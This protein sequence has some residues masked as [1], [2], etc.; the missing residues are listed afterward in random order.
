MES[1]LARQREDRPERRGGARRDRPRRE[2]RY[3]AG[4]IALLFFACTSSTPAGP[5]DLSSEGGDPDGDDSGDDSGSAAV[6]EH[7]GE[8]G[9]NATWGAGE[10]LVTCDVLADGGTLLV[11]A[12]A[13]VSFADGTGLVVGEERAG[14]LTVAGSAEAPVLFSGAGWAGVSFG[15]LA[16]D[17][18]LTQLAVDGASVNIDGA[19]IL[20]V[21][22]S[23]TGATECALVLGGSLAT[24]SGPLEVTG[25]AGT[26]A[27]A[28]FASAHTLPAEGSTYAGNGDDRIVVSGEDF[29]GSV[30]WANLGVP[31]HAEDSIEL[32]G[33]ADE[34]AVLSLAAGVEL[35]MDGGA[36]IELSPDGGAS[37]FVAE[38]TE[39]APVTIVAAGGDAAGFWRGIKVAG[40]TSTFALA[41]TTLSGAGASGASALAIADVTAVLDHVTIERCEG[42]GLEV[43][44]GAFL[45]TSAALVVRECAIPVETTAAALGTLPSGELTGNDADVISVTDGEM[46]TSATWSSLGVPVR[47]DDDL[48]LDGTAVSPAVLTLGP[49]LALRFASGKGLHLSRNDGAAGLIVAG[50]AEAPVT[51]GPWDANTPGAWAG[52]FVGDASVDASTTLTWLDVGYAGGRSL[53]GNV[54]VES[55]SPTLTNVNLH[56]SEEYGLYVDGGA[57]VRT[58]VTYADNVAGDCSGC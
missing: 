36:T 48:T 24:G 21:S 30:R 1:P 2:A 29:A 46:T 41:W 56:H 13:N 25:N 9:A 50:T 31:W 54:H 44:E 43:G 17:S 22:L 38:G 33:T 7:C 47:I 3:A 49:G 51:M 20:A 11:E 40:G 26:P 14:T 32:N 37:G 35:R 58:D 23:I 4:M 5:T 57:P 52:L 15:A 39:E 27:C 42:T 45:E 10:H 19:A 55:A 28:T 34:P 12:G 8:I 6:E 18:S 16:T 53:K